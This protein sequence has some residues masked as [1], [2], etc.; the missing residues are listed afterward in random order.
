MEQRLNELT[1]MR[2]LGCQD[3]RKEVGRT[4]TSGAGEGKEELVFSRMQRF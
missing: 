4:H 1:D 3:H 2:P